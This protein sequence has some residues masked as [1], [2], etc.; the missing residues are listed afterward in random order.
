MN[1]DTAVSAIVTAQMGWP[2]AVV[3]TAVAIAAGAALV[4]FFRYVI[5]GKA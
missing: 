3:W 1:T 4:A 5:G 2:E